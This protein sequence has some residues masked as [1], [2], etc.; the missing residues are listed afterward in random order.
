MQSRW[1]AD[2]QLSESDHYG[3]ITLSNESILHQIFFFSEQNS[4]EGF[5]TI[6]PCLTDNWGAGLA[7]LHL[8]GSVNAWIGNGEKSWIQVR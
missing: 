4:P 8:S 6:L 3:K 2:E 1:I 7:R 5:L